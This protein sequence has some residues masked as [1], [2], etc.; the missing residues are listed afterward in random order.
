MVEDRWELGWTA[1]TGSRS[2]REREERKKARRRKRL[3]HSYNQ[4]NIDDNQVS[5]YAESL[6]DHLSTYR[7]DPLLTVIVCPS[8]PV[9]TCE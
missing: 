2:G 5:S 6:F 1:G 7:I 8:I 4:R 9:L 3:E